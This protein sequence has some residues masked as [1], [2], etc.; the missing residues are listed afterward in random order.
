MS[1]SIGLSKVMYSSSV[2]RIP[3][4][5]SGKLED[6]ELFLTERLTRKKADGSWP[7][8]AIELLM[9]TYKEDPHRFL[10]AEN[11]DVLHPFIYESI[12]EQ[13][14]PFFAHLEARSLQWASKKWNSNLRFVPHHDAHA[15]VA[16]MMSPFEKAMIIVYDG[17]GNKRGDVPFDSL[18]MEDQ[19]QPLEALE[20]M[21]V[22]LFDINE[23]P[24]LKLIEKNWQEFNLADAQVTKKWSDGLGMFYESAAEYIF[25]SNQAAGKV[26]G[27]A[28]YGSPK[29]INTTRA[30]FLGSLDWSMAFEGTSKADWQDSGG[31]ERFSSLAATVQEEFERAF[32]E[33]L[34]HLRRCYPGYDQLI[35]TG[36]CALNCTLNAK[37]LERGYAQKIYIPPFPGD[38]GL[39]LGLAYST[40]E[41]SPEEPLKYSEQPTALG[42]LSSVPTDREIQQK[43]SQYEVSK[44]KDFTEVT[45]L[46]VKGEIIAWFQGRSE[47]GPR[48]LGHRSILASVTR[49]DLKNYLNEK[50]KFREDFRPYGCSVIYEDS[51]T[52]FDIP[53]GFDN[54][55]MSFAVKVKKN[56]REML[57]EVTHI[58]GTSRMQ[59]VR[60]KANPAFYDLL[61]CY[62][63]VTGHGILLNTS[64]NIMGEPIVET[65]DDL[66]RF[67]VQSEIRYLVCGHY[68]VS[69]E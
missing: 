63:S 59:T 62:R 48:A 40:L 44:L 50:I 41:T 61:K 67:F 36:G 4:N 21:S 39:G 5:W 43:F 34:D 51:D 2:G 38:G 11:R 10:I 3:E 53:K 35:L 32:F 30:N 8:K 14:F 15:L 27:L 68:L 7:L 45:E 47:S 56:Y 24:Q 52:Y 55:F 29:T 66:Y 1:I 19:N 46:L 6:C 22:Y 58:D 17:A 13:K 65:I 64:L 25:K 12:L 60:E 49:R 69:K 16:K 23:S 54:P 37:I 28:P 31:V 26:M 18:R 20:E 33:R 42:P 9:A 57:K